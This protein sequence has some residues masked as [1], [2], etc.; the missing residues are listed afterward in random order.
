MGQYTNISFSLHL[1]FSLLVAQA[2]PAPAMAAEG[3]ISTK[4]RFL[5]IRFLKKIENEKKNQKES[6]FGIAFS[7]KTGAAHSCFYGVQ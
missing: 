1:A 5:L 6:H 7:L 3:R 4:S 2:A